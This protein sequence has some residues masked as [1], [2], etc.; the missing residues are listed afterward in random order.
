MQNRNARPSVGVY[1][2]S[3]ICKLKAQDKTPLWHLIG[4]GTGAVTYIAQE[5]IVRFNKCNLYPGSELVVSNALLNGKKKC[6]TLTGHAPTSNLH[7]VLC[8]TARRLEF[9][10]NAWPSVGL[11]T[12][13]TFLEHGYRLRL[14]SMNLLPSIARPEEL[15][16]QTPLPC[17]FHNWLGERRVVRPIIAQLNWPDFRLDDDESKQMTGVD[18]YPTLLSL[19]ALDRRTAA[20]QMEML[21]RVPLPEWL[22]HGSTQRLRQAESL[23]FLSRENRQ[24]KNW[25]LFDGYGSVLMDRIRWR[26]AVVQQTL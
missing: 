7:E 1:N 25:W 4:N 9:T 16:I 3:R 23:F 20:E 12:L 17:A 11:V 24:T 13:Y 18:P 14:S 8:H 15:N 19:P 22:A 6:F 5:K 21:Q 10:L 2:L 26:L